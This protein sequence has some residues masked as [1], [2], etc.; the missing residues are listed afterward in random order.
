MTEDF[1]LEEMAKG[2]IQEVLGNDLRNWK[3]EHKDEKHGRYYEF[4]VF[5]LSENRLN[6]LQKRFD[7]IHIVPLSSKSD[8]I[9]VQ[10]KRIQ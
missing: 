7:L 10:V 2:Y 3:G 9:E 1:D 5:C 8:E 6:L 4:H